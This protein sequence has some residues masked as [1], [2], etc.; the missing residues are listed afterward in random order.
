MLFALKHKIG[1]HGTAECIDV[2]VGMLVGQNVFPL[3]ERIKVR[4]VF[5]KTD[6]HVAITLARA[7]L[8]RQEEVLGQCV[9]FIPA[10]GFVLVRQGKLLLPRQRLR[11]EMRQHRVSRGIQD[12]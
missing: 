9:A 11:R 8:V 10:I 4:I 5:K 12:R 1:L 3:G 7:A 6:C 2:T